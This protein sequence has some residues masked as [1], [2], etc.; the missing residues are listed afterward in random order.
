MDKNSNYTG[1]ADFTFQDGSTYSGEWV[2]GKQEGHGLMIFSNGDRYEGDWKCGRM[3][4]I[5]EYHF[6]NKEKQRFSAV[7]RGQFVDGCREGRG[8]MKYANR[9]I[10]EG[11]WQNNQRT[12]NGVMWFA[13]GDCFCGLW[14]FDHMLRGVYSKY[15]S[16]K[17][18]G[19][20][21]NGQFDVYGKYYW[22]S[23]KWFE[24]T[25]QN[26]KPHNGILISPEGKMA[27]YKDGE[28]I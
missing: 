2:D 5:G 11:T 7:Y 26:G 27:E 12:G 23:G 14:K 19:E 28:I 21:K 25:F 3:H 17:Y 24:V 16:D 10:Y 15:D 9:D 20:I 1:K 4:G 22:K 8:K 6:Y 18:D 13:N